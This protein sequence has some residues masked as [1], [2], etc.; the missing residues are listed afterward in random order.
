LGKIDRE[1]RL[2]GHRGKQRF[3]PQSP[4][5]PDRNP[6]PYFIVAVLA[7]LVIWTVQQNWTQDSN[8]TA[9]SAA[10]KARSAEGDVR[11]VFS[12]DDYPVEA[13][14]NGE[15]GTVRA[16]LD[17]DR[18][19]RVS[20]CMIVQS[21]GFASLDGATCNVLERRAHFT[22]ARDAHGKAVADTYVTPPVKWQLEG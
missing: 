12:A 17:V 11:R 4:V 7:A 19:G 8:P 15:E 14:R 13:L 16:K 6:A 22:P 20:R 9:N 21:S 10:Q 18:Q 2:L 3:H 1:I 5:Q